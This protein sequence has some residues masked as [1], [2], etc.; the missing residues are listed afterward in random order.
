MN[1][2]WIYAHPEARSLNGALRDEGL[3][4]LTGLGH[5]HRQSD[6][7]AMGWNAVVD[8]ADFDQD[9]TPGWSWVRSPSAPTNRVA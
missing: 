1:V 6:L 9:P 4:T 5:R 2:L 7:Y 3:R 8:H